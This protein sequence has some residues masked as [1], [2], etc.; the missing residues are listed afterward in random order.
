M[1]AR[2]AVSNALR[3]AQATSV[4]LRVEGGPHWLSLEVE[5]DGVGVDAVA[6]KPG[7]LGLVGMRERA[8]AIRA[9]LDIGAGA[10]GGVRVHLSWKEEGA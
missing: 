5:D 3:H 4:T 8:L 7:H 10:Q 1:V 9:Q 6:S 2:E